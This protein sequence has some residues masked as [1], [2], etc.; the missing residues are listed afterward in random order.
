MNGGGAGGGGGVENR[1]G[2]GMRPERARGGFVDG[3]LQVWVVGRPLPAPW[4]Q[5]AFNQ[6]HNVGCECLCA[7]VSGRV[8]PV[9]FCLLVCSKGQIR[10]NISLRFFIFFSLF[11]FPSWVFDFGR[12]SFPSSTIACSVGRRRYFKLKSRGLITS[13]LSHFQKGPRPRDREREIYTKY[14]C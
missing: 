9:F 4:L 6:G 14:I 8:C 2:G 12:D 5:C 1:V 7:Y 11:I 3:P 13:L 10:L